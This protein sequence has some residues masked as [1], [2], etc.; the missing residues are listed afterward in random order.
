MQLDA[1]NQ[2]YAGKHPQDIIRHALS[3]PGK[4]VVTTHFGPLEAEIGRASCRE[5]V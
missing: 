2:E 3:L 5:R 4:A 1:L